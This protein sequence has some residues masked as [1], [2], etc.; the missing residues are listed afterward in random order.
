[1]ARAVV[2][3]NRKAADATVR[4]L[5]RLG[6]IEDCDAAAVAAVRALA[7][8]VDAEPGNASLWRE[9]RAALDT[10]AGVGARDGGG[11]ELDRVIEA[12]RSGAQVGDRQDSGPRDTRRRGGAGR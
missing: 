6:R 4:A 2:G 11:D 10:L 7:S 8:A 12:I 5:T 9:Y 3:V 1:M